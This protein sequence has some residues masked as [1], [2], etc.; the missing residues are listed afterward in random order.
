MKRLIDFILRLLGLKSKVVE[1]SEE[2]AK[3][4]YLSI[5]ELEILSKLNAYRLSKGLEPVTNNILVNQIC[6]ENNQRM[7]NDGQI[8]HNG[9]ADRLDKVKSLTNSI[10]AGE[11]LAYGYKSADE[12]I[13]AWSYSPAHKEIM[14]GDFK[15]CGISAIQ[16]ERGKIY[17]TNI[18]IK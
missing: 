9:I 14:E 1:I 16:N 12:V 15:S 5:Y 18:F 13:N 4:R 3:P 7:I 2:L 10:S 17:Y 6:F 8:S 11:N